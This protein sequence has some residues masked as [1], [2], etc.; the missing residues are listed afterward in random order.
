MPQY[1]GRALFLFR[2]YNVSRQYSRHYEH[3]FVR[4]LLSNIEYSGI[5]FSIRKSLCD[6]L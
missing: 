2:I 3:G 1:R 4:R 5:F 6:R